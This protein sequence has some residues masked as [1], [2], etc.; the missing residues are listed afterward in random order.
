MFFVSCIYVFIVLGDFKKIETAQTTTVEL[1]RV[2]G[3]LN[4]LMHEIEASV[5]NYMLTGKNEYLVPY[6]KLQAEYEAQTDKAVG[7]AKNINLDTSSLSDA[8]TLMQQWYAQEAEPSIMDRK[9]LD[10]TPEERAKTTGD[11]N[12]V[13]VEQVLSPTTLRQFQLLFYKMTGLANLVTELDGKAVKEQSFKEFSTFCFGLVRATKKGSAR[14]TENDVKGGKVAMETGKPYAYTCHAGLVDFAVPIIVDGVQIGSWLGGQVLTKQPDIE[15]FK[16]IADDL[17]IDRDAMLKAVKEIPVST[18]EHVESAAKF[19]QLLANSQSEVGNTN[20]M[21][22]KIIKRLDS[23]VGK[24]ILT[25]AG[26]QID[27]FVEKLKQVRLQDQAAMDASLTN[28]KVLLWS[29]LLVFAALAVAIIYFNTRTIRTQIGGDPKAIAELANKIATGDTSLRFDDSEAAQGIYLAIIKMHQQLQA[30]F[31]DMEE[32]R[33]KAE[34]RAVAA[35]EA[36]EEANKARLEA[37]QAKRDG[38]LAAAQTV[39]DIVLR[40]SSA[41]QELSKQIDES[42][43]GAAEQ[44]SRATS[45]AVAMNEMNA[46]VAEVA[47]NAS[48]AATDA[49]NARERATSGNATVIEVEAVIK[50]IND[51][52]SIQEKELNDLS[53]QVEGIESIMNVISDIADQ[54]NLLAL[55]AAIEAARAGEAGRGFAVVADE[56]RKLA[57]KTMNATSEVTS[58]VTAITQAT[59]RNVENMRS[60][61]QEVQNSIS[62]AHTA[63][64]VLED[65]LSISDKNYTQAQNIATA[66]EEQ[67][68]STEEISRSIEQVNM[69]SQETASA[70]L[71]ATQAVSELAKL[72]VELENL[73]EQMKSV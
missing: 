21:W 54:T 35:Q 34:D 26:E 50:A 64:T 29:G 19:L 5:R 6:K 41:A 65:I 38:M 8:H 49:E 66:S 58:A 56:V 22:A 18:Q 72:S 62:M 60:T 3:D 57:E 30:T 69:T 68:Q 23:G 47:K 15:E 37:E 73:V 71:E 31:A 46:T 53:G 7:L 61:R 52:F 28:L 1:I 63:R 2:T 55:N 40:V 24:K 51:R 12:K 17:G 39:E 10:M 20:L 13:K 14:C 32:A 45:T 36:Q 59:A 44:Q 33:K 48:L 67:A 42:S 25:D 16:K 27:V 11:G 4:S 43:K 9:R 70:M